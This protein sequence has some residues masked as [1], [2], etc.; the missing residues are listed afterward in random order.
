MKWLEDYVD[1]FKAKLNLPSDYAVAK[2]LNVGRQAIS[3][4]RTGSVSI[5]K[6]KY[7]RIAQALKIDPLQVIATAEA[8]K[9]KNPELK[10]QWIR[11][12]KEK[13]NN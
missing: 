8:Q 7:L 12:A 4:L 3:K 13:G 9:T 2:E 1:E 10:A 5:G 11:L 6:E